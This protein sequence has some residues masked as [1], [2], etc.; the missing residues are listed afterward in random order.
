MG[1]KR[2]WDKVRRERIVYL[3]GRLPHWVDGW[4]PTFDDRPILR[5][6][7]PKSSVLKPSEDEEN[8]WTLLNLDL[9]G[10]TLAI[11]LPLMFSD[12][13]GAVIPA[14]EFRATKISYSCV[15]IDN[16]SRESVLATLDDIVVG[17]TPEK[18]TSF[19]TALSQIAHLSG[20]ITRGS[21]LTFEHKLRRR[22]PKKNAESV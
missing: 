19:V 9:E 1:R 7:P 14:R 17:D 22:P 6:D 16:I 18:L 20:I 12:S 3:H 15:G 10:S 4:G 8:K 5:E 11:P 2:D 13:T 21:H